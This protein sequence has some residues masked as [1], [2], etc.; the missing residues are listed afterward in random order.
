M[1]IA[2]ERY[3]FSSFKGQ[4]CPASKVSRGPRV[5]FFALSFLFLV[6]PGIK[7]KLEF[8]FS[9]R[10]YFMSFVLQFQFHKAACQAAGY[11]GPLHTCSIYNSTAA[12]KKIG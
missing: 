9:Y 11:Q 12:G 6:P 2:L 1:Y 5:R 4:S 8:Y 3:L 7:F 10:R